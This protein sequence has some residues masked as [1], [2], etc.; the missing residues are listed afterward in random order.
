MTFA[1]FLI[2]GGGI[3][4]GHLVDIFGPRPVIAP[5][6][7]LG[8]VCV[9]LLSQC[10]E[11][12]QV[13]LCQGL[14]FGFACSGTTLP[15]VV[16]V[17]QWFSTRRGLAVGL[18]SWGS[19]FGGLI[20][21]IMI[22][23]LLEQVEFEAAM[24]WAVLPIGFGMVIGALC[25]G[26]PLP[27]KAEVEKGIAS[28]RTCIST[29]GTMSNHSDVEKGNTH[30]SQDTKQSRLGSTGRGHEKGL[31]E[32]SLT[33][34][35]VAAM[36]GRVTP[37]YML[38]FLGPF[39]VMVSV[40]A[41]SAVAILA[42]WLPLYHVPNNGGITFFAIFYGFVSGRYTSLLSLYCAL[43]IG[44]KL[45]DLGLKFGIACLFLAIGALVGI[46]VV[47]AVKDITDRFTGL[48]VMAGA[49]MAIGGG[50]CLA[51]RVRMSR[52]RLRQKV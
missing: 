46:P 50:F 36:V 10:T 21:P 44:D 48:I 4:I 37:D 32:N 52:W 22:A 6:V 42:I 15:A 31:D 47:G 26:S 18:A 16:C 43:L 14:G 9:G 27:T 30:F 28:L 19:S 34:M 20:Y 1:E 39:N 13:L 33:I 12:W 23:R 11:Y 17:T 25:C 40:A 2:F 7:A 29:S 3:P 51:S 45:D 49:T 38:D 24:E 5:F 35:N 8:V 41:T